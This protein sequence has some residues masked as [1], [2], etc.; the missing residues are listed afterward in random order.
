MTVN[1]DEEKNRRTHKKGKRWIYE[2]KSRV[3]RV[4]Q[5]GWVRSKTGFQ[6]LDI[7]GPPFIAHI[8]SA[9]CRIKQL[10]PSAGF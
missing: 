1:A 7:F 6:H 4:D 9:M 10:W 3:D 2:N 5:S 8:L